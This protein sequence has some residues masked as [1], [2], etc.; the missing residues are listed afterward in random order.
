MT[1]WFLGSDIQTL[2]YAFAAER[3]VAAAQGKY[4]VAETHFQKTI[5]TFQRY[6]LPREE[7][8]TLQYWCRA[9]LAAGEPT[10]A[11]EK[12]DAAIEIYR[13]RGLAM[14][15]PRYQPTRASAAAWRRFM[16][17]FL[18]VQIVASKQTRRAVVQV[19]RSPPLTYRWRIPT[20]SNVRA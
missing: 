20:I 14:F 12:F 19:Q 6:C 18:E 17:A 11:I 4:S 1:C 9:L 8:D 5:A 15:E 7:A 3:K 2:F 13:S 10:R 16:F